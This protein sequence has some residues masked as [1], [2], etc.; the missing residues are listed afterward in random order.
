M[1]GKTVTVE[2]NVAQEITATIKKVITGQTACAALADTLS[3]IVPNWALWDGRKAKT[4]AA[5]KKHCAALEM[6]IVQ[7]KEVQGWMRQMAEDYK[8]ALIALSVERKEPKPTAEALQTAVYA[9]VQSV[10]RH[11]PAYFTGKTETGK[12]KARG[13]AKTTVK[14]KGKAKGKTKGKGKGTEKIKSIAE[15]YG[16]SPKALHMGLASIIPAF[17]LLL[18]ERGVKGLPVDALDRAKLLV[19]QACEIIG[20]ITK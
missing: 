12:T 18:D 1:K 6:T 15:M 17:N 9:F 7:G 13:K 20:K 3:T 10:K 2:V 4:P 16:A 14:A 19:S 5:M 11:C 8:G